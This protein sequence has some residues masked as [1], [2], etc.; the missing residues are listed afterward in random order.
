MLGMNLRGTFYNMIY[1]FVLPYGVG[2]K[3]IAL[4][5]QHPE[6]DILLYCCFGAVG[7]NFI[8]LTIR[9]FGSSAITTITTTRKFGSIHIH[10]QTVPD[11]DEAVCD[12]VREREFVVERE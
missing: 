3:A 4:C 10:P 5:I 11:E 1:M 6:W 8:F 7:Q 9:Q 2:Y 12:S